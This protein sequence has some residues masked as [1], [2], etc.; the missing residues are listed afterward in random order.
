R[1]MVDAALKFEGEKTGDIAE[2]IGA[3]IGGIGVEKFHIEAQAVKANIPMYA[4][5][6][7]ESLTDAISVMMKEIAEASDKVISVVQRIIEEKTKEGDSVLIVGVGNSL[8]VG[9]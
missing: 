2:G 6:V 3:A 7:K 4:V 8:G 1:I 9:Q 5:V